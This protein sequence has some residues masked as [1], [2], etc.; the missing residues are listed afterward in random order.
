[1]HDDAVSVRA[2]QEL[3]WAALESHLRDHLEL[4]AEPMDVLQ[5]SGGHANLTYL[6]R[7]GESALVLRRP[8]FGPIAP[9]AHDMKREYRV[10]AQ[11]WRSFPKAPRAFL[12][13]DDESI[14][15][16]PFF[17]ME[18]RLGLVIRDQIPASMAS[19][20]DAGR[21]VFLALVDSMAELHCVDPAE[22]GLADLGKP[23]GFMARQVSG[24]QRRWELVA[25]DDPPLAMRDVKER[26][27]RTMP[28][29]VRVSILHNDLKLD[30]CQFDPADPDHVTAMFDW[31]MA[32][33]GDPLADLGTLLGYSYDT[34]G[35]PSG[36]EAAI[37]IGPRDEAVGRYAAAL[38]IDVELLDWYEA[39]ACWKT[40][41]VLAQLAE[42]QRRAPNG[43]EDRPDYA[44]RIP[45]LAERA[46]ALVR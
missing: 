10:L 15:G 34:D 27:E 22:A 20:A 16:A 42:R 38:G 21:R 18:Q 6:L 19:H 41:V 2:G 5:F 36:R 40:A 44:E 8:P 25:P 33:L 37:G 14:V 43:D 13:S 26:L 30:N 32:T 29:P 39:F 4:P 12:F 46:L 28:A 17:V 24:W 23:D 3:D 9:G 35:Q 45:A 31:D 1:M 11:L 7:F